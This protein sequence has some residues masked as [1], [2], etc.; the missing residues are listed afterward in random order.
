MNIGEKLKIIRKD[1]GLTQEKLSDIT[2]I[3]IASIQRYELGKRQ[4]T[5]KTVNKFAE[6]LEVSIDE[7]IL[8]ETS[9]NEL[10]EF[11]NNFQND[12]LNISNRDNVIYDKGF[13]DGLKTALKIIEGEDY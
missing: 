6:A 5:M 8:G 4:P 9:I 10:K 7:L 3:S 13:L 11:I 1:R 12:F 2:K